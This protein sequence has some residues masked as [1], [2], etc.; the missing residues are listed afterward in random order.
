MW[1]LDKGITTGYTATTFGPTLECNRAQVVTFLYRAAGYPEIENRE[2]PPFTDIV[3]GEF[4]FDALLWALENNIT[5]G[6]SATA[7]GPGSLCNRAQVV[8]FLY[9]AYAK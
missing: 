6:I 5:Q 8:T 3:Y 9:R 4:Y 2:N 7:F 1:A